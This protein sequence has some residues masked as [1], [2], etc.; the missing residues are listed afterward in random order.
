MG[1]KYLALVI[2]ASLDEHPCHDLGYPSLRSQVCRLEESHLYSKASCFSDSA[3]TVSWWHWIGPK[4][5]N[6]H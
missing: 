2:T 5:L 3:L 4:Q 6:E 1:A